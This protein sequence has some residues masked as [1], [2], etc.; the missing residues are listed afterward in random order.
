MN[1]LGRFFLF[2]SISLVISAGLSAEEPVYPS[3]FNITSDYSISSDRVA[4]ADTFIISRTLINEESFDLNGLYFSDILP[5]EF[6]I[7]DQTI[8]INGAEPEIITVGPIPD[9]IMSGYD[10]YHW[11]VDSRGEYAGIDYVIN[12]GDTV[13]L[14]LFIVSNAVGLF[15]LPLHSTVFNGNGP[16]FFATS[17]PIEVEIVLSLDVGD[18]NIPESF[19]SDFI[20]SRA[21]PNPFNSS[22]NIEY[23]GK[24][25]ERRPMSFEI[26]DIIGRKIY[27]RDFV[28]NSDNSNIS[29]NVD[30]SV[31]SGIYFYSLT[32]GTRKT[33]G[34][35]ILLK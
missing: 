20:I 17:G 10:C 13:T 1:K 22:V 19:P 26:Y 6:S 34:K 9:Y 27:K 5:P 24:N 25:L 8:R 15:T 29:W 2:L 16:G 21:Y 18:D 7:I 32:D 14:D 35:I 4:L 31:S 23:S 28:S 3:M 33:A 12:P 30:E 11:I